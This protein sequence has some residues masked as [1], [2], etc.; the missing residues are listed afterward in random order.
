V[1]PGAHFLILYYP[2]PTPRVSSHG[3][4][5]YICA[6]VWGAREL[7]R[8]GV[9]VGELSCGTYR[10]NAKLIYPPPR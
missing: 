7:A 1:E 10:S 3:F 9:W 4:V 8:A 5:E 2:P 6:G